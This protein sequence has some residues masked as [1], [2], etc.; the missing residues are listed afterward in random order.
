MKKDEADKEKRRVQIPPRPPT[1]FPKKQFFS[2]SS[3][4]QAI[5]T[6]SFDYSSSVSYCSAISLHFT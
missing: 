1:F 2:K 4:Q 3:K 5:F 6:V